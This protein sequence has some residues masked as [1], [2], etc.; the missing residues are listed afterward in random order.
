MLYGSKKEPKRIFGTSTEKYK[1]FYKAAEIVA[2]GAMEFLELVVTYWKP[3]AD[4]HA[5]IMPDGFEVKIPVIQ[6]AQDLIYIPEFDQEILYQY[7][8]IEGTAKGISLA[9]NICHAT[10]S[11]VMRE[12]VRK[13]SDIEILPI[14]DEYLTHPNNVD[15]V[16]KAYRETLAEIA[17]SNLL[18]DILS[19]LSGQVENVEMVDKCI[20]D[21]IR[22]SEYAIS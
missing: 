5:W 22:K 4:E 17:E 1:A 12:V 3:Y 10:D 19:Q 7:S 18:N 11:Y 21:N 9:A 15:Q 16:R 8:R 2:P 14:H 13:C 20:A 6:T